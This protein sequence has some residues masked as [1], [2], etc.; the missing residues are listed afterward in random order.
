[1][2]KFAL[3]DNFDQIIVTVQSE[4]I[5]KAVKYFSIMKKL[6]TPSLLTV[7]KVVE[8]VI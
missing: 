7:F 6:P 2:K 4:N 5:E 3:K 8:V 1:M